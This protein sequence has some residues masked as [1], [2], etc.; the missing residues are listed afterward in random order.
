LPI[1][2]KSGDA[3][4]SAFIHRDQ[5]DRSVAEDSVSIVRKVPRTVVAHLFGNMAF[6]GGGG[7]FGRNLQRG[8]RQRQY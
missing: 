4:D 7:R 6:H 5:Q 3:L 8:E 1:A 2:A